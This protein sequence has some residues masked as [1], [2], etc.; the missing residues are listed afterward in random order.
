[1]SATGD[2]TT[3]TYPGIDSYTTKKTCINAAG[4]QNLNREYATAAAGTLISGETDSQYLFKV[5]DTTFILLDT[6]SEGNYFVMCNAFGAAT[7]AV[8]SGFGNVEN[9]FAARRFNVESTESVAY[10]INNSISTYVPASMQDYMLTKRWYSEYDCTCA[11]AEHSAHSTSCKLALPSWTELEQYRDKI[12]WSGLGK[13]GETHM[14]TRTTIMKLDGV[15][16]PAAI[17]MY[18]TT[19]EPTAILFKGDT[20]VNNAQVRP[21]FFLDKDFFKKVAVDVTSVGANALAEIKKYEMTDLASIYDV[22]E[23]GQLGFDVGMEDNSDQVPTAYRSALSSLTQGSVMKD[24]DGVSIDS[25]HAKY[26]NTSD[27]YTFTVDGKSYVLLGEDESGDL[28][29]SSKTVYYGDQEGALWTATTS[30]AA[31]DYVFSVDNE[32]S[33]ASTFNSETW[34]S[35]NIP[36]LMQNQ[37]K[38]KVWWTEHDVAAYE[39]ID[40]WRT[41]AKIA[42]PSYAEIKQYSDRYPFGSVKSDN[43]EWL[44]SFQLIDGTLK[45]IGLIDDGKIRSSAIGYY[46]SYYRPVFYLDKDFFKNVNIGVDSIGSA[47]KAE[48]VE[49]YELSE[50]T[51]TYT[52]A[53]LISLGYDE[54]EVKL[55]ADRTLVSTY[56]TEDAYTASRTTV[57]LAAIDASAETPAENLLTLEEK[58][59][60]YLDTDTDGNMFVM[61]NE[62]Y[63]PDE[64]GMLPYATTETED[65]NKIY[66]PSVTGNIAATVNSSDYISAVVPASVI[67]GYLNDKKW[68]V[69]TDYVTPYYV[70]AKVVLPSAA[71]ISAYYTKIGGWN[72]INNNNSYTRTPYFADGAISGYFTMTVNPEVEKNLRFNKNM[73]SAMQKQRPV[74][75]IDKDYFL[76]TV[77]DPAAMGDNVKQYMRASFTRAEL[78]AQGYSDTQLA[79][80]GYATAP[81]AENVAIEAAAYAVGQTLT[82]SYDFVADKTGMSETASKT[83]MQWYRS[84]TANGTYTAIEGATGATYTLTNADLNCYIKFGVQPANVDLVSSTVY[85]SDATAK[86]ADKADFLFTNAKL[87]DASGNDVVD[88]NGETAV[89]A[90]VTIENVGEAAEDKVIIIA[91]YDADNT[92]KAVNITTENVVLGSDEYTIAVDGFTGAVAWSAKL[93]VWDDIETIKPLYGKTF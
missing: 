61:V 42:L 74:F 44:R 68:Y 3:S 78:A 69:E 66:N 5:D 15:Y 7:R 48:I 79:S 36:S 58:E 14:Q 87:V 35:S 24:K 54:N 70:T 67:N 19:S 38:D 27:E 6:D 63:I 55:A 13:F 75:F 60:I 33:I 85:Y 80:I 76:D 57:S 88:I 34:I 86:I 32:N 56:P 84:T 1:V 45:A 91:V 46:K 93:M 10:T 8:V 62:F 49:K 21:V 53:D 17:G 51:S 72:A 89:T 83:V 71:E 64:N 12:G 18:P 59:L 65:A 81:S 29:V 31:A 47:I 37:L 20:N 77:V 41:T 73:T 30:T 9:S 43:R 50:L 16:M 23:L 40:A 26:E 92:L 52:S 28:F 4:T 82:G 22:T 90:K 2:G 25:T 11:D 39:D